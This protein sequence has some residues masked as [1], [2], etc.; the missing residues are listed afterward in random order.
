MSSSIDAPP[1]VSGYELHRPIGRGRFGEVWLASESATGAHRAVKIIRKDSA[2]PGAAQSASSRVELAGVIEYQRVAGDQF[3]LLQILHVAE[4]PG[5]LFIA[6]ELADD[7][8]GQSG[9]SIST[10]QPKTLAAVLQQRGRIPPGEA[11]DITGQILCGLAAL[12]DKGLIHRDVKPA[13][14]LYVGGR[15]KLCDPSLVVPMGGPQGSSGSVGYVPRDDRPDQS[16][17]LFAVG[18]VLY[19]MLTGRHATQFPELPEDLF[20]DRER[21]ADSWA[22]IR[23]MNK[24]AHPKAAEGFQTAGEM[25]RKIDRWRR[26]PW[27]KRHPVAF[28][29]VLIA[30]VL[31]VLAVAAQM[32]PSAL[33]Q[34]AD[35]P[36]TAPP[37]ADEPPTPPLR[38]DTVDVRSVRRVPNEDARQEVILGFS[39]GSRASFWPAGPLKGSPVKVDF[40]GD[41]Q[42]LVVVGFDA[43]A[44][45]DYAGAIAA[46]D[47]LECRTQSS[48]RPVLPSS[49]RHPPQICEE[50]PAV[51][52]VTGDPCHG[53]ALW[54]GDLDGER[55]EELIVAS[56]HHFGPAQLIVFGREWT[57]LGEYWHFGWPDYDTRWGPRPIEVGGRSCMAFP[58]DANEWPEGRRRPEEDTYYSAILILENEALLRPAGPNPSRDGFWSMNEWINRSSSQPPVAY[59]HVAHG[60]PAHID[61]GWDLLGFKSMG[62]RDDALLLLELWNGV[63]FDL[64]AGLTVLDVRTDPELLTSPTP[65]PDAVWKRTWPPDSPAQSRGRRPADLDGEVIDRGPPSE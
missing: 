35:R 33:W 14:V 24:A 31:C 4:T 53:I 56:M 18:R 7:L 40:A 12:H 60:K 20:A 3:H 49:S 28:G 11:L 9:W 19:A 54:A 29:A 26:W 5:C 48:P 62:S 45:G 38:L 16:R 65:E 46:F 52:D 44:P 15:V 57:R 58:M 63:S 36:P 13:N 42:Y 43:S 34:R 25:L 22:A 37:R 59:G 2:L 55:G 39:D 23:L 61:H 51:F 41:G 6:M 10:Y 27:R 64:D 17:D 32:F 47:P 50:P 30:C 8:H 21:I 1:S